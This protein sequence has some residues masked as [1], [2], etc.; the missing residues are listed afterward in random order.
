MIH[1]MRNWGQALP[2]RIARPYRRYPPGLSQKSIM[3]GSKS[4]PASL[5]SRWKHLQHHGRDSV[6]RWRRTPQHVS[7]SGCFPIAL[8][9]VQK[10]AWQPDWH[11]RASFIM[12]KLRA[13]CAN[14]ALCAFTRV[15]DIHS[16]LLALTILLR[17]GPIYTRR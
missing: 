15:I 2:I 8:Y 16:K 1:T 12:R 3:F 4:T 6:R 11:S 9:S 13:H 5:A 10:N 14:R 17:G 7:G